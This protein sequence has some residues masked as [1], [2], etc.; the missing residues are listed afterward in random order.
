MTDYYSYVNHNLSDILGQLTF[1]SCY[2]LLFKL[3]QRFLN[4][5]AND[6]NVT[7]RVQE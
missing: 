5:V 2:T 7:Y 1:Y 3:K 4:A 6:I